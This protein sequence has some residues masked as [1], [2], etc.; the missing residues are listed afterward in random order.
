ME[1][2]SGQALL[3]T[4]SF[5]DKG[6]LTSTGEVEKRFINEIAFLKQVL[7]NQGFEEGKGLQK[8]IAE[9]IDRDQSAVSK[10]WSKLP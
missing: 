7:G 8:R 3:E 2:E 1:S 6:L 4:P 10:V 9:V 5:T